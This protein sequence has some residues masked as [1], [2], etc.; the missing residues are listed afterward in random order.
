MASAYHEL[1]RT[2][3]VESPLEKIRQ[4]ERGETSRQI[5]DDMDGLYR[6]RPLTGLVGSGPTDPKGIPKAIGQRRAWL[7]GSG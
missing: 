7:R 6:R 5:H 1:A 2:A 3:I 4:G